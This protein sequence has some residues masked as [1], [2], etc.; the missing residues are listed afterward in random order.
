M[1]ELTINGDFSVRYVSL[2]EGIN[3]QQPRFS[4]GRNL[5]IY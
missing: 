2:P 3:Y 5:S 4:S 1:G